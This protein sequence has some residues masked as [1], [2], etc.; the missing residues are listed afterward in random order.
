MISMAVMS[1]GVNLVPGQKVTAVILHID[2]Q[3]THVHV[4]IL[5]RLLEKK[6]PVRFT[7]FVKAFDF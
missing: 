5:S 1:A 3:S 2:L 4:S 7:T 6:K